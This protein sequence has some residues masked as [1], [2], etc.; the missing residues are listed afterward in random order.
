[1]SKHW[2]VDTNA[3]QDEIVNAFRE[4]FFTRP[5]MGTRLKVWS[6]AAQMQSNLKWE[7]T[8]VENALVAAVMVSGGIREAVADSKRGPGSGIGT[9]VALAVD[10]DTDVRQAQLWLGDYNTFVGFN[11]QG[12]V[13]KSYTKQVASQLLAAGHTANAHK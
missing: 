10:G 8:G 5:T 3:S 2:Y 9:T 12:D 13:L 7:P 11:Q 6:K 4:V 1:M